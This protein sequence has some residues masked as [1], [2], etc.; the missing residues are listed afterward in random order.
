MKDNCRKTLAALVLAWVFSSS[1]FANAGIMWT[2]VAPPPPPPPPTTSE[3]LQDDG[4]MHTG[5]TDA[6]TDVGLGLLDIVTRL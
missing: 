5:A 3:A 1:T 6:L 4:L 2:E